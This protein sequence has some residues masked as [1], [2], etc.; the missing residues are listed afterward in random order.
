MKNR[1]LVPLTI[2][3]M[4]IA[5]KLAQKVEEVQITLPEEYQ[6]FAEVFSKEASQRMPPS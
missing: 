1:R 6:E 5:S 4:S 3:K 2:G